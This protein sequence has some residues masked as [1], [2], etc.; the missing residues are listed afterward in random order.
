MAKLSEEEQKA[1]GVMA[2]QKLYTY[3]S[4]LIKR[5]GK[6]MPTTQWQVAE[7]RLKAKADRNTIRTDDKRP[8]VNDFRNHYESSRAYL[9]QRD[10][11]FKVKA[12]PAFI[13]DSAIMKRA[14]C[15][16][17]YLERI[18]HEQEC[19]IAQSQKLASAL[20]R[21]VGFTLVIFDKKKWMPSIRYLPARDVRLD[22]D[23]DGILENAGWCAYKE[24][25]AIEDLKATYP[26]VTKAD[27]DLLKT[28]KGGS[29]LTEEELEKEKDE[30]KESFS[31][32]TVWH[33][34]ARNA[35]A[36]RTF[37]D[38]TDEQDLPTPRMA[39]KMKLNTPRRYIVL[40]EGLN[41]PLRNDDKW[42]FDLDHNEFPINRLSFNH[43]PEDLYGFTDY[44]QMER[45]DELSDQIMQYLEQDA[46]FS[47]IRKYGAGKGAEAISQETIED[48]INSNKRSVLLDI[49]DESGN[50]LLKEIT[51][52]TTNSSLPGHYELMHEQAKEASGQ[53]ELMS[54]S[55]ADFKDV[56]AIGVRY[57][58]QKL[59]QRVNLRLGGPRGY[60]KSIAEDAVKMLEIAHQKVPKFSSIGI[61]REVEQLDEKTNEM[62]TTP[63]E[64]M[65]SLPWKD[66]KKA[67]MKGG[68]LLKLGVD[69]IVGPELAKFWVTSDEVP[70]QDIRLST[71]V[72]VV[73]GSTRSITQEQRVAE[74]KDYYS[75]ILWPTIYQPMMRLDLAKKYNEHIGKLM[76]LDRVEDYLPDDGDI[77]KFIEQQRQA[78]EEERQ[79]AQSAQ[80]D[81]SGDEIRKQAAADAQLER[82]GAKA[83]L[84]MEKEQQKAEFE[85][86]KGKMQLEIARQKVTSQQPAGT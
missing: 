81:Q 62:V 6:K 65:E 46:Y 74:L 40:A 8:V 36:I 33:I 47:A 83:Q 25:L 73:A 11:S 29:V 51:V 34:F 30:D 21:N 15:E 7:D 67:I 35:A 58:E 16:K 82:D 71:E 9:D 84:E 12:A 41:K 66:A 14:E 42:D 72:M 59:H 80:P 5:A 61:I 70:I 24:N 39:E 31:V 69:V 49:L 28:N 52:G 78:A 77:Q 10:P 50:L 55:I 20:V 76:G 85:Q 54:D 19:Q 13:N 23:C 79:A 68:Q 4:G 48:F 43:Q 45:M 3:W 75:N 26:Q 60:E 44:Q 86:D 64:V 57:Q 2:G 53:N 38:D 37:K 1:A 18:W 17:L 32:V 56:T 63:Q 22:P 27:I